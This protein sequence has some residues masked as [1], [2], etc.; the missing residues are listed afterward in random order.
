MASAT[1]INRLAQKTRTALFGRLAPNI[2]AEWD[3]ALASFQ[4]ARDAVGGALIELNQFPADVPAV[5][6]LARDLSALSREMDATASAIQETSSFG[7]G[8]PARSLF[9][10]SGIGFLAAPLTIFALDRLTARADQLLNRLPAVPG[11]PA[12]A[13]LG[14]SYTPWGSFGGDMWEWWHADT[15]QREYEAVGKTAP[16]IEE[17]ESGALQDAARDARE[18]ALNIAAGFSKTLVLVAV[19]AVAVFV[20]PRVLPKK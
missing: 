15:V 6:T 19:I 8:V 1:A 13:G 5:R 9:T 4:G 17:I 2:R 16:P 3:E 11:S 10:L 7:G 20:V 18:G 14:E 12:L